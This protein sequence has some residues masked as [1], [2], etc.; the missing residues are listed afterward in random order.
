MKNQPIGVFDSGV[1]GLTVLRTLIERLPYESYIYLGDTA[2]LPYGTKTGET[3]TRY[4]LQASAALVDRGIKALVIACNTASAYALPALR[5]RYPGM[6]VIGVIEAGAEEACQVSRSGR[7]A[8][9]STDSTARSGAYPAAILK[10]RPRAQIVSIACSLLVALAEEGWT[11]GSIVGQVLEKYLSP[12]FARDPPDTVVLGCTHFPVLKR[13]IETVLGPDIA[14]VDSGSTAAAF[15]EQ[16]LRKAGELA[17]GKT[18]TDIRFLATD[19]SDRFAR[20]AQA[21]LG[22][23]I[24]ALAIETIDLSPFSRVD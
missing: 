1:G 21:F 11:E 8:V 9:M 18:Q 10:V 22:S 14:L 3:V 5:Q 20:V 4:A 17:N 13:E 15:V 7:I 12:A 19:G 2:R 6:P 24:R 16:T 23:S